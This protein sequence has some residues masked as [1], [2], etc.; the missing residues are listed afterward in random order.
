MQAKGRREDERRRH[1]R[2]SSNM[3]ERRLL[4]RPCH[5]SVSRLLLLFISTV[6]LWAG[7][8]AATALPFQGTH[9]AVPLRLRGGI[10]Q[11]GMND[12]FR[13]RR[14][15][16]TAIKRIQSELAELKREPQDFFCA[17]PLPDDMLDWHFVLLGAENTTFEKGL[18][19]GRIML[20]QDYPMKPPRVIFLTETGRFEVGVPVCLSIT[21]H[22][23]ECWQVHYCSLLLPPHLFQCMHQY[24]HL[25]AR[26]SQ[27]VAATT[28]PTL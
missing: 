14:P 28:A 18:F 1:K 24:M 6:T 17:E 16:P 22:H 8:A 12:G 5:I 7:T 10:D 25:N 4:V 11:Y 9:A 23:A 21:S 2:G 13:N 15:S 27:R 3:A 20:D 26:S 19:H